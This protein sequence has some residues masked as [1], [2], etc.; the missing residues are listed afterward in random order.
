MSIGL[1]LL[2]S[3]DPVTVNLFSHAL[4]ELS[5]SPDICRDMPAAVGLLNCK[6]FDAIIVDLQL[7]G[8]SGLIFDEVHL[9]A[10]NR[11]AVTFGISA[12][13]AE[14]ATFRQ[15]SQF[16]FDRPLSAKSIRNTLKPAYGMILR[17][18]RRYF[19]CPLSIPV[20]I[21][22]ESREEVHC[23]SV[24]ISAGGIAVNTSVPIVPGENVR[25]QFTLPD[26][27]VS[28]VAVSTVCW[29][30]E[31]NL[32]VRFLSMSGEQKSELQAWLSRKLE[33]MLPESVAEQ[34]RKVANL[35]SD[36]DSKAR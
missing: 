1:A 26:R 35:E 29:S 3:A 31:G 34:F 16:M 14:S 22:R 12:G 9:S 7:A 28:F 13:D 24:N 5:I 18:R 20:V 2:V 8:E 23:K 19:R 30:R 11:T 27:T 6:K 17:E 36:L 25:L 32:G 15:S 4:Q 33:E 10:S 21:Q